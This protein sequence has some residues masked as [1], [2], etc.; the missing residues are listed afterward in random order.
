[1]CDS[2]IGSELL[3]E[4]E[5]FDDCAVTVDVLLL[6]IAEKV[7]SVTDHLEKTTS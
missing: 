1:M 3:S 7:S 2:P 5:L 6:E 4:T